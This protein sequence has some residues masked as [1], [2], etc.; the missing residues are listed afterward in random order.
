MFYVAVN[1]NQK[2]ACFAIMKRRKPA[3]ALT[4]PRPCKVRNVL[5]TRNIRHTKR[6]QPYLKYAHPFCWKPTSLEHILRETLELVN[7]YGIYSKIDSCDG[8]TCVWR[9]ASQQMYLRRT[10][11]GDTESIRSP[12]PLCVC[13]NLRGFIFQ[14]ENANWPRCEP[15]RDPSERSAIKMWPPFAYEIRPV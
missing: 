10:A 9:L 12:L 4:H 7:I 1:G 13:P 14:F 6:Q 8:N 5:S 15:E 11:A 2:R 3:T